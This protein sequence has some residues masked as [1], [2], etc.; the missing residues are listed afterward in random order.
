M[1]IL[2]RPMGMRHAPLVDIPEA[3][4]PNVEDP[5]I[6]YFDVGR[7]VRRALSG[8]SQIS[9]FFLEIMGMCFF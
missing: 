6:Q 8:L 2:R 9:E 7:R 4:A 1:G 5:L 3:T